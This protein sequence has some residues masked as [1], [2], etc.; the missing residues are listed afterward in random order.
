MG[1]ICRTVAEN[2][3]TIHQQEHLT[4]NTAYSCCILNK[5]LLIVCMK[6]TLFGAHTPSMMKTHNFKSKC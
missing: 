5:A 3:L 2:F 1:T 4:Y 6:V